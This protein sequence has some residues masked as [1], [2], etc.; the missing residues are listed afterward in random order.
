MTVTFT[1]ARCK[2]APLKNASSVRLLEIHPGKGPRIFCSLQVPDLAG[3]PTYDALPY[4]WGD[5]RPASEVGCAV[6]GVS[7]YQPARIMCNGQEFKPPLILKQE[8]NTIYK[9]DVESTP[10]AP[11]GMTSISETL[12]CVSWTSSTKVRQQ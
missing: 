1:H 12:M 7:A 5:L 6:E 8:Q 4:N 3:K 9:T 10:F 11:T 2:Y